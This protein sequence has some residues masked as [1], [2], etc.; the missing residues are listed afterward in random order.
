MLKNYFSIAWRNIRKNGL[1]SVVNITGLSIGIAFTLLIAVYIWS[2]TKVNGGLRE[3]GQQYILQSKW[4][5]ASQGYKEA[6]MG[7]LPRMLKEQYPHLVKNYFRIDGVTTNVSKGE[8]SFRQEVAICDTTLLDMYGFKLLHGHP[9][10]AFSAP[11]ST[12]VTAE[13]AQKYFGKTDVIGESL[14]VESFSGTRQEFQITGVMAPTAKNTVTHW[15]DAPQQLFIPLANQ[16]YFNRMPLDDWNNQYTL[17]FIELQ[18]GVQPSAL[19]KPLRDI[20]RAH[21]SPAIVSALQPYMVGLK[22]YY[23][24]YNNGMVKKMLYALSLIALFILLMAMIN[25]VNMSI[26]RSASRMKEIGIRKVMGGLKRQLIIQFLTESVLLVFFATVLALAICIP[27]GSFFG[28]IVG[29]KLPAA[30]T[31]P[32]YFFVL[33]FVLA[34]L[35]G[36]IAGLYPALVLTS[37]RSVD[38]LKGKLTGV[39]DHVL[40]RK[41]LVAFQFG[42]AIVVLVSAILVSKQTDLF[43]SDHLGYDKDMIVAAQVPRDWTPQGVRRMENVR[44]Q[45]AAMPEVQSVT[46][47]FELP[48]GNNSGSFSMYRAGTDSTTAVPSKIL[49]TDERYAATYAIPMAAGRF[50]GENDSMKTVINRTQAAALGWKDPAEAVGRQVRV[51]GDPFVYTVS[52]VTEDFHFSSMQEAISPISFLHVKR[53]STYRFLALKMKPGNIGHTIGAIEKK[54]AA[55]M[56][57]APFEYVFIDDALKKLYRTELQ[58]KKAFYTATGISLIIVLLGVLGLISLSVQKRTREIGIRKV[59]GASVQGII[60]LFM[61]EFAVVMVA[62]VVSACPVAYWFMNNWLNG[63][64]YRI[65]ITAQPFI[66]TIG[67]LGALTALLIVTQTVKTALANPT[68]SLR[69]D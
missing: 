53:T 33:P 4:K 52:G 39:K 25:F 23:L 12:V 27:L 14:T 45:L 13:C 56:P 6:T 17:G 63:Y 64:V 48:N 62:A 50:F 68:K 67:L 66:I 15:A 19:D 7:P 42:T 21:A 30:G 41:S 20:L 58:M 59:L 18:P 3:A 54:W 11:F 31:L 36:V 29:S 55:L 47:A 44:N 38:S 28:S 34:V 24:V 37:L 9:A 26:S 5:D 60:A 16:P 51:P 22:E 8:K 1:Y 65:G 49:M 57:G 40:L 46:L 2:E 61:K 43:F 32:L 69:T 35:T 10:T